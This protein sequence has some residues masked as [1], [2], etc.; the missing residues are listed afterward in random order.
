MHDKWMI[1][2]LRHLFSLDE[3]GQFLFWEGSSSGEEQGFDHEEFAQMEH[4]D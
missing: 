2:E 3:K 1:H 4:R